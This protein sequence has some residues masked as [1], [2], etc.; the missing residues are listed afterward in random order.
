MS[1]KN[2]IICIRY[3][4]GQISRTKKPETV[5]QPEKE[6]AQSATVRVIRTANSYNSKDQK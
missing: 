4:G 5:T 6:S 3:Q 1:K 2:K